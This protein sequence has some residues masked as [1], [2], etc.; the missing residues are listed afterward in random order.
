MDVLFDILGGLIAAD[1][2]ATKQNART[3]MLTAASMPAKPADGAFDIEAYKKKA[4][5]A[6]SDPNED[7]QLTPEEIQA[8]PLLRTNPDRFVILPIEYPDVWAMYKKA[9]GKT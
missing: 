5:A 7:T 2:S 3:K 1:S 6:L 4:K 8:E 9:V